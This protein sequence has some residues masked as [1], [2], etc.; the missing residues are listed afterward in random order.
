ML[1]I[2]Q[3]TPIAKRTT[4]IIGT[5]GIVKKIFTDVDVLIHG[6]EVVE[7]LQLGI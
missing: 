5:D 6:E 4:F 2:Y 7:V 1:S 3:N